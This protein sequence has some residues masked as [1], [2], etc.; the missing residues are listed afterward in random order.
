M[1]Q[2]LTSLQNPRVKAVVKL[3]RRPHRDET[4]LMVVEGYRELKRALENGWKPK[5]LFFCPELYLGKNEPELVERCRAA[6]ADIFE[7]SERVFRKMAYR[8]RP[9]G[10]LA[11]G[12]QIR[13]KL[14]D[15]RL[16]SPQ[17]LILVAESLEKPGNL[18][19]LLRSADAAGADAVIV[20]DPTT[21][22]N[23]PNVV[24][25]SIGALFA[26]PV[27]EADSQEALAWLRER[28]IQVVAASPHAEIEYTS[29]DFTRPTAIVVGSEQYG[30]KSYW[31]ENADVRVRIPMYGQAD[32]LN[33]S[34]AGTILLFEA[35]RQR[36]SGQRDQRKTT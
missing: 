34:A 32:S 14:S 26:V 15:L 12:P 33:V 8:D 5:A 17:P 2:R 4:G 7:C 22:I 28:R 29:V 9:E 11:T 23:N 10:L 35:V 3:A 27:A 36:H 20:C 31:L 19:T 13:R 30:L 25:A 18:G 21:D 6:G 1:E 24:R 16:S